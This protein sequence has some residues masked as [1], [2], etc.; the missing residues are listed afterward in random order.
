[1]AQF[2]PP[3]GQLNQSKSKQMIPLLIEAITGLVSFWFLFV[4]QG[5]SLVSSIL[6]AILLGY[7]PQYFNGLEKKGGNHWPVSFE[8]LDLLV[9]NMKVVLTCI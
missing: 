8:W 4:W 1:M 3:H 7:L 2:T 9:A 6:G 5:K